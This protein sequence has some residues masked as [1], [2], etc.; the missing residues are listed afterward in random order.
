MTKSKGEQVTDQGPATPGGGAGHT[1]WW[2]RPPL[3]HATRGCDRLVHLVTSPFCLFNP[4]DG[5][6]LR[7]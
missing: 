2:R 5:K 3:G 4:L 7:A 1:W 6:T